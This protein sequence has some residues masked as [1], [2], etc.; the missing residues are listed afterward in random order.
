MNGEIGFAQS[1]E[2]A[3]GIRRQPG[4]AIGQ[5]QASSNDGAVCRKRAT[6]GHPF[7]RTAPRRRPRRPLGRGFVAREG[8]CRGGADGFFVPGLVNPF[9]VRKLCERATLPINVMMSDEPDRGREFAGSGP[10][11]SVSGPRHSLPKRQSWNAVQGLCRDTPQAGGLR[12]LA[13]PEV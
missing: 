6:Y 2:M 13:A 3:E 8:L 5:R 7:S 4:D 10:R 9:L 11:G 1:E 12:A